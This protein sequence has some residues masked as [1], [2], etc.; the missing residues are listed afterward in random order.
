MKIYEIKLTTETGEL[1]VIDYIQ[2]EQRNSLSL[3]FFATLE[4]V[5]PSVPES[6]LRGSYDIIQYMS[7]NNLLL[8]CLT[9]SGTQVS[10]YS[11]DVLLQRG[12]SLS[13]LA[14]KFIQ[15]NISVEDVSRSIAAIE[16]V[17]YYKNRLKQ[18]QT[19][20]Q[21]K[22]KQDY[23]QQTPNEIHTKGFLCD[24]ENLFIR[25]GSSNTLLI[26]T[27]K[28]IANLRDNKFQPEFAN[29]LL[30]NKL[31]QDLIPRFII[32]QNSKI[33]LDV[34]AYALRSG[35]PLLIQ[36]PTSASKSLNEQIASVGLYNQLPLI[37]ALSE[38][39]EVGDLLGRKILRWRGTS[40]LTYVP[41][42]LADAY[43]SGRVLLLDEFD[44]CPPKVLSSILSALDGNTI[45]IEG[46]S[47]H[48]HQNFR[49]IATLNGETEK[50]TS[51]Q[52]N[53]LPSEVLA[54]FQ[55]ISFSE[56]DLTECNQI[57]SQLMEQ[58]VPNLI[59]KSNN[60]ADI[61]KSVAI[62]YA[63]QKRSDKSRGE[64]AMTLRN[65]S[66]A[67]D[68]MMLSKQK[69]NKPRDACQVAYIA[70][71]PSQD[72]GQFKKWLDELEK[73]D[74]EKSDDFKELRNEIIQATTEMH[75]H[76]HPQ[77]ID[78]AVY[79]I[80]AAQVGLHIL[81]E[82]PSGCGISTLAKFI[83]LFCTK[84]NLKNKQTEIPTVL[85]GPE[86]IVE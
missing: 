18:Q 13:N 10:I 46:K 8:H 27:A 11:L 70:Q 64:A 4:A 45:E 86:S 2:Y 26:D 38:Q 23:Y 20:L 1:Q 43:K 63:N 78:A 12:I 29:K 9:Y 40:M 30:K 50:F 79:G 85:L 19:K 61:H 51:Q 47:I 75:I 67:L 68:L 15:L 52:R 44:L 83:A 39:T 42:V 58:S 74:P 32:T 71:I 60:I 54:R 56:M 48:R 25:E 84:A 28:H 33:R 35:V 34:V 24:G 49:L 17:A 16:A 31:I 65:F 3:A 81:L 21:K 37:Y 76:P 80:A 7:T 77:F 82:G 5:V 6:A 36:G 69:Q 14:S 22:Q 73:N 53:I 57:F 59:R 72:R 66:A 55:T 41:G 62:Y